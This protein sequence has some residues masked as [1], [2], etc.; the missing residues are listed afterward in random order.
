M[1]YHSPQLHY[2]HVLIV[3]M[4]VHVHLFLRL[5]DFDIVAKVKY[6]VLDHLQV[7]VVTPQVVKVFANFIEVPEDPPPD[8]DGLVDRGIF[9]ELQTKV[10]SPQGNSTLLT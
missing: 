10:C 7:V 5:C 6:D 9:K 3:L 8:I 4:I 1:C 2:V